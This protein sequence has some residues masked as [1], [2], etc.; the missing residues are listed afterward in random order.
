MPNSWWICEPTSS[1]SFLSS[2]RKSAVR[3]DFGAIRPLRKQPGSQRG[4]ESAI[5][6]LDS[7]DTNQRLDRAWR[8]IADSAISPTIDAAVWQP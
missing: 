4:T 7:C 6:T 2:L 1:S 8:V 3:W 5:T